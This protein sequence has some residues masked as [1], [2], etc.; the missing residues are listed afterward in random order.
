MKKFN[1]KVTKA[2]LKA[3]AKND[4]QA[5]AILN[6]LKSPFSPAMKPGQSSDERLAT[7]RKVKTKRFGVPYGMSN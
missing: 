4:G 3:N 6:A 7:Y 5:S 1:S 2:H